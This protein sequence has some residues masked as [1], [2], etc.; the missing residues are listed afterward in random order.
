MGV[1]VSVEWNV[2]VPSVLGAPIRR[3]VYSVKHISWDR[4]QRRAIPT[5]SH[6]A[7]QTEMVGQAI[8]CNRSSGHQLQAGYSVGRLLPRSDYQLQRFF[9]SGFL[10]FWFF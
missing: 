4:I 6:F 2:R 7:Q 5:G 9:N 1:V 8:K 3:G 10:T